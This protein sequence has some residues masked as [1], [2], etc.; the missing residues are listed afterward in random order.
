MSLVHAEAGKNI[1]NA[2]ESNF[3]SI[4]E[5]GKRFDLLSVFSI[6]KRI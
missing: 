5:T 4:A 3:S 6:S 1:R 2:V